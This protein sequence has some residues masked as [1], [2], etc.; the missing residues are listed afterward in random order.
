M[1]KASKRRSRLVKRRAQVLAQ[2]Q[3]PIV[4]PEPPPGLPE[5]VASGMAAQ[6]TRSYSGPIPPPEMLREFNAVDPGRAAKLMQLAEDQTRHRMALEKS[7]IRSDIYKSWAG[8][9]SAFLITMTSLGLGTYL[10]VNGHSIEG[11]VFGGA[12]IAGVVA[13]FIYGTASRKA[14]RVEK[15]QSMA[16]KGKPKVP[17]RR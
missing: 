5:V 17:A 8:L 2:Q 9:A 10:I 13:A 11:S 12:S 7:V 3:P 15:Q 1:S 16:G 4:P 6:L 14:E